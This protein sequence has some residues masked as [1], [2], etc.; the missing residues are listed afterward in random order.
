MEDG[1]TRKHTLHTIGSGAVR[2]RAP[3]RAR[4]GLSVVVPV[5]VLHMFLTLS[6]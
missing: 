4:F 5:S 1:P 3:V 6:T 2:A